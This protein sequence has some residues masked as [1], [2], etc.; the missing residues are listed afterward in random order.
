M[1]TRRPNTPGDGQCDEATDVLLL[2]DASGSTA[3]NFARFR[4]ISVDLVQG[5]RI[6]PGAARVALT[7]F[8]D[9]GWLVFGF[10]AYQ[11]Q[12]TLVAAISAVAHPRDNAGGASG[13]A[14][15]WA[16]QTALSGA[17][18]AKVV[19]M[20][21]RPTNEARRTFMD[22]AMKLH[23]APHVTAVAV[24]PAGQPELQWEM[25]FA[26]RRGGAVYHGLGSASRHLPVAAYILAD[27]FCQPTTT[28]TTTLPPTTEEPA[29]PTTPPAA[30]TT[31]VATTTPDEEGSGDVT[32]VPTTTPPEADP[33]APVDV[34][35]ML[36]ES[37]STA[38]NYDKTITFMQQLTDF[39]RINDKTVQVGA[40]GFMDFAQLHFAFDST[41]NADELQYMLQRIRHPNTN[42]NELLGRALRFVRTQLLAKDDYGYRGG[43]V[44]VFV[45]IDA[46]LRGWELEYAGE[47]AAKLLEAFPHARIV[48]LLTGSA[49]MD[50]VTAPTVVGPGGQFFLLRSLR[51]TIR[52]HS[53]AD[54]IAHSVFCPA[55]TVPFSYVRATGD[56]ASGLPGVGASGTLALGL[57][58]AVVA[59]IAA[60]VAIVAVRHRRQQ[61]VHLEWEPM[62]LT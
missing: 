24:I 57:A 30:D 19:I 6:G 39:L 26:T 29:E 17:R 49:E 3:D 9:N 5:L 41:H 32:E 52:D 16:G 28:T 47:Q 44:V 21:D 59:I 36:D 10:D 56:S 4:E 61:S 25:E 31:E 33:C 53:K 34:L 43:A 12:A 40:L 22:K 14:L 37:G 35:Y 60:V 55:A 23:T 18:A 42:Q 15:R 48:G 50:G 20:T 8:Q 45:I 1:T 38:D 46:E 13:Q 2:W 7:L 54:M 11:T 27:V 58:L 62:V 51:D